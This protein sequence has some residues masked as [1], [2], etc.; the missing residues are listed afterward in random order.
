MVRR[1]ARVLVGAGSIRARSASRSLAGEG[2][3]ERPGDLAVVLAEAEQ[4]ITR[5]GAMSALPHSSNVELV[6]LGRRG[7]S[8]PW[9]RVGTTG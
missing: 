4:P 6:L 5:S 2:R 8:P 3:F 1:Q 7:A 9:G